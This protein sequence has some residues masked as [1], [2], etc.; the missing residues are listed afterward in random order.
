MAAIH[1]IADFNKSLIGV[2]RRFGEDT[3]VVVIF[4][5]EDSAPLQ[6]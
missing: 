2:S 6:K 1:G 4:A 5:Y 3:T